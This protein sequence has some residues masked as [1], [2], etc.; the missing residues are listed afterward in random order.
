VKD[1]FAQIL[2]RIHYTVG[3]VDIGTGKKVTLRFVTYLSYLSK[4]TEINEKS[5]LPSDLFLVV[6]NILGH[7][8]NR[9]RFQKYKLTLVTK[10]T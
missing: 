4:V 1:T 3:W 8:L 7:E 9:G 2:Y 10:C 5:V 6:Q